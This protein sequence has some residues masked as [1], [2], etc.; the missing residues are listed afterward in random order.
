MYATS[1][2]TRQQ[3]IYALRKAVKEVFGS[4][5]EGVCQKKDSTLRHSHGSRFMARRLQE[6]LKFLGIRQSPRYVGE[7]NQRVCGE[8]DKNTERTTPLGAKLPE[9]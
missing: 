6:E 4:Y 1:R 8:N 3:A 5:E 9:P 7:P 2:A